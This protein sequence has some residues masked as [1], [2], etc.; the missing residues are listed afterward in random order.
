MGSCRIDGVAPYTVPVE[1]NGAVPI[2]VQDQTTPPLDALFARSLSNF[3]IAVQIIPSGLTAL[4]YVFTADAGHGIAPSD[5]ILLL[6]E[7][8]NRSFFAMV[9]TVAVNVITVDRPIDHAYPITSLGRI[10][11]TNMNVNGSIT[12]VIYTIRA[13]SV[14][15]DVVRFIMTMTDASAMDY[16]T[17]GGLPALTHGLVM[18]IYNGFQSTVF[19]FK[20][21]GEISQFCYDIDFAIKAPAGNFGLGARISFGGTDKHGVVIRIQDDDVIQWVVQDDLTGLLTLRVAAEGHLTFEE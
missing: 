4:T 14:P 9:I 15:T 10:V 11:Q 6:D 2:N 7:A 20:T 16:S 8:E 21:N 17:F 12:P 19:C 18:R 13:G 3:T 1:S 5:E